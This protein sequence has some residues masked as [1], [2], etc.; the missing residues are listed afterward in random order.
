MTAPLFLPAMAVATCLGSGKAA[1][2]AP[3]FQGSRH[4]LVPRDDV[5]PGRRVFLGACAD[6]FPDPLADCP[7]LDCRNNRLLAALL[8]EIEAPVRAAIRAHGP[9]RVAVVLG[10]STA[11]IAEGERAVDR[12]L[13]E[14]RWPEG[15]DYRQQETGN[16]A[17]F[18]ARRLGLVGP[19]YVI[20]TA[21]S[22]SGKAFASARRLIRLGLADAAVVGGADTLC[23]MTVAG[24]SSLE[25]VSPTPCNPFSRNRN[26]ITVGEGG[27]LFLLTRD[28]AEVALLGIGEGSDAHHVS[29]PDPSGAG[30]RATMNAALADAGLNPDEIAYLN[31]HGTATPLNDAME[32]RATHAVFGEAVVCGSTKAMTGHT[33]GAAGA[34]EAAILWLTLSRRWNPKGRIPPH[35]GTGKPTPSCQP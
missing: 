30:A 3:L 23:R 35:C 31:L 22:S 9:H 19:A 29:A 8:A 2:V 16:A 28:E 4:G 32:S 11:G 12:Y 25:A 18:V 15:Y 21:C 33:L 5:L 14:D 1:T 13:R 26:G 6:D 20:A 27:A 17:A 34:V 10:T 24:F 7:E